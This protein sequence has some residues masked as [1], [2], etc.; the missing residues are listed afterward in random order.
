MKATL[1]AS[2]KKDHLVGIP[3]LTETL[4]TKH[5]PDLAAT[6]KG[7]MHRTQQNLRSNQKSI[8]NVNTHPK[9]DNNAP[10]KMYCCPALADYDKKQS[11]PTVQVN[12]LFVLM[13]EVNTY[14]SHMYM[15]QMCSWFIPSKHNLKKTLLIPLKMCIVFSQPKN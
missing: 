1:L 10:C 6:E 14:Y 5:L 9:Q 4:V 11:I 3:G 12:F 7:H 15:M 2:I 8:T 13:M